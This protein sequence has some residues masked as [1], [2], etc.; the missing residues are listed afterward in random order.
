MGYLRLFDHP[1]VQVR[2]KFLAGQQ[3]VFVFYKGSADALVYCGAAT[4]AMFEATPGESGHADEAGD[5]FCLKRLG[6]PQTA[7]DHY[8]L[9]RRMTIARALR[10][11]GVHQELRRQAEQEAL[12]DAVSCLMRRPFL[13]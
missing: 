11:P 5:F 9:F 3:T 8:R 10:L 2:C 4:R 7:A 13:H 6:K 1:T 12:Y